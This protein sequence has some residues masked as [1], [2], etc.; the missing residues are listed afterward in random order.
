MPIQADLT[1]NFN[2]LCAY[3]FEAMTGL[4]QL[5]VELALPADTLDIGDL[6]RA[7]KVASR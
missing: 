4:V 2:N 5:V 1:R 7:Q 3:V 6:A